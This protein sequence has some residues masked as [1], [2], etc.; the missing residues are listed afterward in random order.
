ML[1]IMKKMVTDITNIKQRTSQREDGSS[2][3]NGAEAKLAPITQDSPSQGPTTGPT[4]GPINWRGQA[5]LGGVPN[6]SNPFSTHPHS[7]AF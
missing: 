4:A 2:Q 3:S 7:S 1:S 6:P 5:L